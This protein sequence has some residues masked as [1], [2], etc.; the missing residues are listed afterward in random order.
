VGKN[1]RETKAAAVQT[2]EAMSD[3]E[4]RKKLDELSPEEQA[5]FLRAFELALRKRRI[6][7]LGY[8]ASVLALLLGLLWA[9]YIYGKTLGSGEFMAWVFLVPLLLAGIILLS[10]GRLARRVK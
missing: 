9:L 4:F 5:M 10:V 8:A 3:E 2:G 6:L 1:K 7:L